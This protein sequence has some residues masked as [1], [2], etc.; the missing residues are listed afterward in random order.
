MHHQIYKDKTSKEIYD[1]ARSLM[2]SKQFNRAQIL[3]EECLKMRYNDFQ[4]GGGFA[5][6]LSIIHYELAKTLNA[7]TAE[8]SNPSRRELMKYHQSAS[9]NFYQ[10]YQL[11]SMI[12]GPAHSLTAETREDYDRSRRTS[13]L[14]QSADLFKINPAPAA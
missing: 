4:S 1:D 7:I 8:L 5:A 14:L 10:A 11:R 3:L 13:I 9:R 12:F 2:S 6:D